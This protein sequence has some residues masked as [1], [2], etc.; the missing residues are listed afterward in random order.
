MQ[1]KVI[2]AVLGRTIFSMS[3]VIAVRENG[4]SGNF[5]GFQ[6][7]RT[8][9]ECSDCKDSAVVYRI[10]YTEDQQTSLTEHRSTALRRIKAE[11]PKHSDRITLMGFRI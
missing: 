4:E 5:I 10:L 7:D 6:V 9:L 1:A 2:V 11:H 8:T 3:M